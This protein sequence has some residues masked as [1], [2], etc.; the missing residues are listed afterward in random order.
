MIILHIFWNGTEPPAFWAEGQPRKDAPAGFAPHALAMAPL[1]REVRS[2]VWYPDGFVGGHPVTVELPTAGDVPVPSYASPVAAAVPRPWKVEALV[3]SWANLLMFLSD[4]RGRE[5]GPGV[6]L[7]PD[8]LHVAELFRFAARL[9]A[10]GHY[11]PSLVVAGK[12][13]GGAGGFVARWSGALTAAEHLRLRALTPA[14]DAFIVH[15][16]LDAL[17]RQASMTALTR[18]AAPNEKFETVHDAWLAAL[19][20]ENGGMSWPD[21]AEVET[22]QR[23]LEA[24]SS[25][26]VEL[27]EDRAVLRFALVPPADE[28][29]TWRIRLASVP[30][31]RRLLRALGQA[32]SVFPPLRAMLA[33]DGMLAVELARA[34]ADSFLRSGAAALVAAG[35]AVDIPAGLAGEHLSAEADVV[36]RSDAAPDAA[37]TATITVRVDG[38]PV[39]EEDLVFLLDQGSPLVFFHDRWIEVDRN[40]LREALRAVRATKARR[41]LL[42]DAVMFSL[43]TARAG[44]LRVSAVRAHGWLRGLLNELSGGDAFKVLPAPAS[45]HGALRP[46]QLRGASWLSFLAKWGFGACLAD[47]MGL[48]KTV[49]TIAFLLRAKDCGVKRPALIVAPLTVVG[50][51]THELARFAPSLKVLVHQGTARAAGMTFAR[52][53]AAADVVVTSYSLL[54]RDF[55]DMA[56]AEFSA[57]ILDEAQTIKNPLTRAARAARAL[58]VPVRIALTGTPL[59]NRVGDLWS[60]EEFLNPGLLGS[61]ADFADDFARPIESDA[62]SPAAA[63]LRRVLAPFILRRLK[64][65]AAVAAELGEKRE[66]REYCPLTAEQRRLYE[67]A[68][69]EFR[70]DGAAARGEP[71]VARRGRILALLTRLKEVCDHPALAE[72]TD[73]PLDD[74]SGKLARLDEI[75]EEVFDR[76]ESALVFT[77]YAKMGRLLRAHLLDVFGRTMPFLHGGL[78]AAAR[79]AE[80]E[81][82]RTGTVPAAFILSLKAGGFGL[83]LTR[84]T[85]VVHFDRWWNPAVE[86]QATDRA[87]RIGQEKTV[88]VHTFICSGTVEDHVDALLESK[89][90]LASG[91]V[92]SGEGFLASMGDAE[93]AKMV[94]L[95][96]AGTE[97]SAP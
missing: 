66:T 34:D 97:G 20:R 42:R 22:F 90:R 18:A 53:A 17:V 62:A 27:P 96:D 13:D 48:G 78:D 57:L 50:N 25:A 70:A 35:Y 4:V 44:R 1:L 91:L 84:A 14:G 15:D 55:A 74:R 81:A 40:V 9:A 80:I 33:E 73:G 75:L 67:D 92:A 79:E 3:P 2:F 38:E 65:D 10:E 36:P 88:F 24:W 59:E 86:N 23:D 82:F 93:L 60:L 85:H 7:A 19:R 69:A 46:Y 47:D 54:V 76:G 64:T 72:G 5:F 16:L 21:A 87:H 68:L 30:R 37:V 58:E 8:V 56:S 26:Q 28:A 52:E 43:G 77:Q 49:Q 45:F 11:L 83:N 6:F 41:L 63:R 51:W 95:D 29:G 61:R 39:T 31:D 94:A 71:A 12:K 32:V 89:R